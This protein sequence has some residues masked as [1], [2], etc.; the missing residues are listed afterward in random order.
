MRGAILYFSG[1]GNTEFVAKQFKRQ[2]EEREIECSIFDISKKRSLIDSYDFFVFGCPIY[3]QSFTQYFTNWVVKN[4][5]NGKSRKCI[6][7][8]TSSNEPGIGIIEL[9][10]ILS[11]KGFDVFIKETLIMPDN[12]YLDNFEKPS[13]VE[14]EKLKEK[15]VQKIIKIIESFIS[16]DRIE[17]D[18]PDQKLKE[19]TDTFR[20]FENSSGNWAKDNLKVDMNICVKCGKCAKNCPTHN[21]NIGDAV[22]FKDKCISGQK[23][24]HFCPVNAF[25]FKGSKVVQYKI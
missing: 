16:E 9:S 18:M 19:G 2:F 10:N 20:K 21:I 8:S 23:C 15:A 4:I 1:T 17:M 14:I 24:I 11:A 25:L 13:Y 7:F 5:N 12:N 22:T 6:V 3:A